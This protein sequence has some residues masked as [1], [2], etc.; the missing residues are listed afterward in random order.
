MARSKATRG[1]LGD[2]PPGGRGWRA[3]GRPAPGV[4]AMAASSPLAPLRGC[5]GVVEIGP[6][7]AAHLDRGKR[8][9]REC[10]WCV[11]VVACCAC[12]V[13]VVVWKRE[14]RNDKVERE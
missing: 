4:E 9:E 8:E 7:A 11:A 2:A 10:V 14:E 12:Y 13:C 1:G 5:V 3:G 6:A